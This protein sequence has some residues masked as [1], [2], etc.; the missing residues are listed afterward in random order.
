[1]AQRKIVTTEDNNPV[2]RQ[3]ARKVHH[4]DAS[5]KRLVDDMFETLYAN[6]GAGLA[7]P[8]IGQSIRLFVVDDDEHKFAMFNPEIV[9]AE[10]AVLGIEAC[11]SIPG[12]AGEN[13]SRAEKIVVKGQDVRGKNMRV[14]AEGWFARILQ[15]E[16][17]HLDG[18]LFP[19]RLSTPDDLFRVRE[20]DENEAQQAAERR[21]QRQQRGSKDTKDMRDVKGTKAVTSR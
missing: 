14:N 12:Y 3:K 2:L 17:D 6:D 10:G 11:L 16:I 4:F 8:Q 21:V 15:H 7:A 13:V 9:K 5:L 18:I 19:D 1:M 20:M